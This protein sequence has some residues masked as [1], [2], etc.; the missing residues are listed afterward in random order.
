MV[1]HATSYSTLVTVYLELLLW[2]FYRVLFHYLGLM[3]LHYDRSQNKV[4]LTPYSVTIANIVGLFWVF[5]LTE[6]LP[7]NAMQLG[8]VISLLMQPRS[9][10]EN[11]I[12]LINKFLRISPHLFFRYERKFQ[13]NGTLP[14][15]FIIRFSI[16]D[17]LLKT[18]GNPLVLA[19]GGLLI[20]IKT[21]NWLIHIS[22]MV[23]SS[24]ISLIF[25]Y[26]EFVHKEIAAIGKRLPVAV[27]RMDHRA[28]SR[29]KRRLVHMQ[30][31]NKMCSQLIKMIFECLGIQLFF[32]MY[33]NIN[34]LMTFRF[35]KNNTM[36]RNI[37]NGMVLQSFLISFGKLTTMYHTHLQ[38]N[39]MMP[40]YDFDEFRSNHN[41]VQKTLST[42]RAED[43][44]ELINQ[45]SM[46]HLL[47]PPLQILGLFAPNERF[48]FSIIF[49]FG[50]IAYLKIMWELAALKAGNNLQF[51][52]S[53]Y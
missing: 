16:V 5:L 24:T 8:F 48:L 51:E 45:D 4:K 11:R 31:L 44:S 2:R 23:V 30:N 25:K 35:E 47:K 19:A 9:V 20:N 50:T 33:F 22:C 18:G 12:R 14:L 39:H 40:K 29:M 36:L 49:A 34:F 41:W 46:H 10:F 13:L 27:L 7:I 43:W 42:W 37:I 6:N 38:D 26:I 15:A 1:N 53:H 52:R 17:F 21:P 28:V 3:R 32:L